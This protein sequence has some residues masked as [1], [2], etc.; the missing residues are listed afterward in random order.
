MK[1]NLKA[2]QDEAL[3]T[4]D[5]F[6]ERNNQ[7]KAMDDMAYSRWELPEQLS[8][9]D[10]IRKTVSPAPANALTTSVKVL[11]AETPKLK[12]TPTG[13][14]PED[15]KTAS[16]IE[17]GLMWEFRNAAKRSQTKLV[18]DIVRSG[19]QY[20]E[21]AVYIDYLPWMY[22]GKTSK[23]IDRL[24]R[25]GNFVITPY[26]P[27]CVYP[28]YSPVGLESVLLAQP[29]SAIEL[30][31]HWGDRANELKNYIMNENKGEDMTVRYYDY[32]DD[33][34]RT[35]WVTFAEDDTK[36]R[37]TFLNEERDRSFIPWAIRNTGTALEKSPDLQ[38]I[39]FLSSVYRANMW[40]TMNLVQ[41]LITSEVITYA[42]APRSVIEGPGNDD[43]GVEYGE[44]N[45][46]VRPPI[47]VTYRELNP[48]QIDRALTEI[49]DR[50]K[51]DLDAATSVQVLQNLNF[52]AGTAYATINAVLQT[53][54]ASLQ[55]YKVLAEQA[56][57]D[58]FETMLLW[59]DET[60]GEIAARETGKRN[61]DY[62]S[63]YQV[64]K[65]DFS[66][67]A[68]YLDVE[69]NASAP[70]D[71]MQRINAGTLMYQL[72]YPKSRVFEDL[73]VPDPEQ[74]AAER[75]QE[76]LV[77]NEVS[78]QMQQRQAEAQMQIQ[79]LQQQIAMMQQQ[80]QQAQIPQMQGQNMQNMRTTQPPSPGFSNVQGQG[81]DPNLQGE[82]PQT[83]ASGL[84]R[85]ELNRA[86]TGGEPLAEI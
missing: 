15:R 57:V 77:N 73:N 64:T 56:L 11:G 6:R 38:R 69:L 36:D 24:L 30:V 78:I 42:A 67:N 10:F 17:R 51:A 85:E 70:T 33:F 50:T 68:I 1:R 76:D 8:N 13:P 28:R 62:G 29:M 35:V 44:P 32:T 61:N 79:L 4:I 9:A 48:P 21:I 7:N 37:W 59:L 5:E 80:A 55:P 71:F 41:T 45:Q 18:P 82:P 12:F 39:P 22:K 83:A 75:V 81:F 74:V 49:L 46:P 63:Q 3:R 20:G 65:A 53:A 16:K 27:T 34:Q 52:P 66:P 14:D 54:I 19:L 58:V 84:T 25:M 60:G 2:I 23:R 47:G 31:R 43:V 86:T 40:R 26:N 72:G